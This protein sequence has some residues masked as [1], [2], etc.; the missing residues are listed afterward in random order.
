MNL[1]HKMF[2][3]VFHR[4]LTLVK[5]LEEVDGLGEV[6]VPDKVD[7]VLDEH[8]LILHGSV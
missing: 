7:D 2:F 6:V 3:K 5:G 8:S 4:F 1:S